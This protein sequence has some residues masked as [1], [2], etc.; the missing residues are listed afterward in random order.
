MSKKLTLTDLSWIVKIDVDNLCGF[1]QFLADKYK[2]L[3]FYE[4]VASPTYFSIPN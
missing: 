3:V 4:N 1:F 2:S